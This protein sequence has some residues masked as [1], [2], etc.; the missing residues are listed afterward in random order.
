MQT[1]IR[2]MRLVKRSGDTSPGAFASLRETD[3][4]MA[5]NVS[6]EQFHA[7]PQRRKGGG[8]FHDAP[9]ALC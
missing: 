9:S 2:E 3:R 1:Y 7:K 5:T 8:L 4:Q 6:S